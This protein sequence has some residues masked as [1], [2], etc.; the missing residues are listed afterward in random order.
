MVFRNKLHFPK[1]LNGFS[2]VCGVSDC[3][4]SA[5]FCFSISAVVLLVQKAAFLSLNPT[6]KSDICHVSQSGKNSGDCACTSTRTCF[7]LFVCFYLFF[8]K[9]S[10]GFIVINEKM[11]K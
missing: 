1:G 2:I 7:F 11:T 8:T 3:L 4:S 6:S 5:I 9:K 10:E